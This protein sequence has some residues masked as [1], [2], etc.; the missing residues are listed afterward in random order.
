MLD[1][2][3]DLAERVKLTDEELKD[4]T[5]FRKFQDDE[6]VKLKADINVESKIVEDQITFIDEAK[7]VNKEQDEKFRY[8]A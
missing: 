8:L 4:V 6:L 5:E 3:L 7:K 2:K 1:E